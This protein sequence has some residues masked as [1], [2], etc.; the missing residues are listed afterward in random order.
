MAHVTTPAIPS[1]WTKPW[2]VI[3]PW[4]RT[5]NTF[6]ES[7]SAAPQGSAASSLGSGETASNFPPP[8]AGSTVGVGSGSGEAGAGAGFVERGRGVKTDT[9]GPGSWG[10]RDVFRAAWLALSW[11]GWALAGLVK[12]LQA[13]LVL[14]TLQT[15]LTVRTRPVGCL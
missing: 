7:S 8:S 9:E 3:S 15:N 14:A 12:V 4:W 2:R 5:G 1:L 11:A 6:A 10:W 13:V